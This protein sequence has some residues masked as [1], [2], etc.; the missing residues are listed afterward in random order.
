MTDITVRF[1]PSRNGATVLVAGLDDARACAAMAAMGSSLTSQAQ[2]L[3]DHVAS[4]F[5]G[6]PCGGLD[7]GLGFSPSVVHRKGALA[8]LMSFTMVV[9][10]AR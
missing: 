7:G 3:P 2:H 10:G 4:W 1:L 8:A 9:G 5:D 6:L